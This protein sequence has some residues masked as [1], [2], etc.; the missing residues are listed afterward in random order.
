[1]R[2]FVGVWPPGEVMRRLADLP[3]PALRRLR[4]TTEPQWHVTLAFLGEVDP[5]Q[6]D[7]LTEA[8]S[9]AARS[10]SGPVA[11][12]AGP[13]VERLG[14]GVLCVG[15]YGLDQVASAVGRAA[16]PFSPEPPGKTFRGHLTLARGV[17]R[18]VVPAGAAG[19]PFEARWTVDA[20]SLVCSELR[21]DGAVYR[22]LQRAP[23]GSGSTIARRGDGAE[24]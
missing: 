22:D 23:L 15:L 24:E 5:A 7:P 6:L 20:V 19:A 21:P 8:L 14:R 13:V 17:G 11:V 3:R 1:M 9:A 12:R 4:W 18:S 2:L 16:A 10:L